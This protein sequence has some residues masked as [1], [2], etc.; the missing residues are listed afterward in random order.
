MF[1]THLSR[2]IAE[3][4][5]GGSNLGVLCLVHR[6]ENCKRLLVERECHVKVAAR[7]QY[8]SQVLHALCH[9]C[10]SVAQ[11]RTLGGIDALKGELSGGVLADLK[12]NERHIR[13]NRHCLQV[14]GA[15]HGLGNG[16]RAPEQ[17]Q[18]LVEIATQPQYLGMAIQAL[19]G[20][21]GGATKT[22][23]HTRHEARGKINGRDRENI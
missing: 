9:V 3:V 19:G 7:P 11:R 14:L 5:Q 22:D 1:C 21:G 18:G 12:L 8:R 10:V 4:A 17:G 23:R 20:G 6:L 15:H 16:Q 2:N 13:Q